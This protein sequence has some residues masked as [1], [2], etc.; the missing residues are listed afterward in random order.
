MLASG[1]AAAKPPQESF[2]DVLEARA[3]REDDKCTSVQNVAIITRD[4]DGALRL[5]LRLAEPI[6][7]QCMQTIVDFL[8][9]HD[10][11]DDLED[12]L[13]AMDENDNG[14]IDVEEFELGLKEM[15]FD[16]SSDENCGFKDVLPKVVRILGSIFVS[17]TALTGC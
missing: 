9:S 17:S 7:Q 14:E 1:N 12:A 4:E 13:R 16:L 2:Q 6:V 10:R 8:K 11:L 15:G 5:D 3:A